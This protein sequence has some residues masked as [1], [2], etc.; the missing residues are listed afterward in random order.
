MS[1]RVTRFSGIFALRGM[2]FLPS[3]SVEALLIMGGHDGIRGASIERA[4]RARRRRIRRPRGRPRRSRYLLLFWKQVTLTPHTPLYHNR[5]SELSATAV[6]PKAKYKSSVPF[7][8]LITSAISANSLGDSETVPRVCHDRA[9]PPIRPAAQPS[10]A[11][12][13]APQR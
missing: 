3:H 11:T 2:R 1:A 6:K 9:L 8:F 5:D 10:T 4:R 13:T 12:H 7:A